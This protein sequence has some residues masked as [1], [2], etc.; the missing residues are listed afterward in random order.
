MIFRMT[1]DERRYHHTLEKGKVVSTRLHMNK[2]IPI[3]SNIANY[4]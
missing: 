3:F 2:W 4:N 1:T